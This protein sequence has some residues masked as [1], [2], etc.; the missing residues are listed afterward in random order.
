MAVQQFLMMG[1]SASVGRTITTG[2][3]WVGLQNNYGQSGLGDA[4]DN[5]STI[6]QLGSLETWQNTESPGQGGSN[7]NVVK[8]DGTL[9]GWGRNNSGVLGLGDTTQ[10][11]SPVQVGALT[12]WLEA[13]NIGGAA[14]AI[15]T[16]NTLWTWGENYIGQL[17][18]GNTTS[19]TSPVQVGSGT[20]WAHT[21]PTGANH[22]WLVVMKTDGGIYYSGTGTSGLGNVSSFTQIGTETGFTDVTLTGLALVAW[23]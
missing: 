14:M 17:G 2:Q 3:R 23:K 21:L 4:T 1:R 5:K 8:S 6:T 19:R 9:W 16:D 18:H 15:K 20:D 22:D 13:G 7:R 11:T 10:R 12:D